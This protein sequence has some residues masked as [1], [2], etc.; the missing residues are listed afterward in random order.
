[1]APDQKTQT[2]EIEPDVVVIGGGGGLAAALAAGEHGANV[3]VLE[4]RKNLGGNTAM[5][6]GLMAAE[7]PVQKRLK[8]NARK[9]DI[10]RTA[11]AYSHW[12]VDP[13]I[14]RAFVNKSGDTIR[15]LEEMGISFVD[16]PN[17]Y[18]N[19]IP[20]VYHVV[21]G[22]GTNLVKVLADKG[23]DL[24]VKILRETAASRILTNGGGVSGVLARCK[25]REIN[26]GAKSVVIATGGY[27]GN[28]ELLKRYCPDY[29]DD[30]RVYGVPNMGD[31]LLMA[32]DIGAATEGLGMALYVGPFFSG[33]VQVFVVCVESN[34][35]WVNRNGMRY[36][37]ES[38]HWASE[39]G[40]ALNRQPGK[41]S[42]TLFDE[43]VKRSFIE[44]GLMKGIHRSFPSGSKVSGLEELLQKEAAKGTVRIAGSWEALAEWIAR[45]SPSA[46]EDYRGVQ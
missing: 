7:S 23:K 22:Y 40:N 3:V 11:V 43:A 41:I 31:G 8:I 35:I 27:A 21:K 1:M 42:Y 26:I 28:K 37:D 46:R 10:F 24:G 13:D 9:E 14:V 25:D 33:P 38:V 30:L 4:K 6:R 34:T 5:A 18:V 20:R 32:T 12:K 19:Q 15:W 45:R 39:L 29:T 16:V 2:L 36:I 17:Y 44:D